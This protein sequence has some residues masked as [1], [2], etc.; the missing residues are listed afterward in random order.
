MLQFSLYGSEVWGANLL[1]PSKLISLDN[2]SGYF[3]TEFD[4]LY[5]QFLKYI[6]G[7]NSK[8]CN[9]AV[10]SEIGAFPYAL[11]ILKSVCKIWYRIIHHSPNELLFDAYKCNSEQMTLHK[12]DWL[13]TVKDTLCTIGCEDIWFNGGDEFGDFPTIMIQNLLK[14][15]FLIQWH[16]DLTLQ[17]QPDKKLRT[18]SKFKTQF[19]LETYLIVLKD[20]NV[21]KNFTK[22]RI[23][24]HN[25]NIEVG[26]H[27]RPH[28]IPEHLRTCNTCKKIENEYHYVIECKRFD[29]SR[30]ELFKNMTEIFVNFDI[31]HS[32]EKFTMLM[33][34]DDP[35]IAMEMAKFVK[36]TVKIRGQ[37]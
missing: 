3:K 2:V 27:K 30:K 6:L 32:E 1:P 11:K 8:A 20:I 16:N 21:R 12:S 28:K 29:E 18:Y 33:S 7:V 13:G 25:L 4:K 36:E 22:L 37:L 9:F 19:Q 31:L 24:A 35:E 10:L 5:L 17:S 14:E 34:S 15:K 23:S 26:R